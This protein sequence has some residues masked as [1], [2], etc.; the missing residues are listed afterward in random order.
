MIT[1]TAIF[2][3][4]SL[5]KN[6]QRQQFAYTKDMKSYITQIIDKNITKNVCQPFNS[7]DFFINDLSVTS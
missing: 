2:E 5:M 3:L 4:K 6:F 1:I 7:T